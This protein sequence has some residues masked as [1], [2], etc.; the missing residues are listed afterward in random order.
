[1]R[2]K[3]GFSSWS[4]AGVVHGC[5]HHEFYF[6]LV[7][8]PLSA[9][10]L[11]VDVVAFLPVYFKSVLDWDAV[12]DV[13]EVFLFDDADG[14]FLLAVD[15]GD[16]LFDASATRFAWTWGWLHGVLFLDLLYLYNVK[17]YYT[18]LLTNRPKTVIPMHSR[19][20]IDGSRKDNMPT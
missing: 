17:S 5:F 16:D 19:H 2:I 1:M 11:V 6:L 8:L 9:G 13:E 20:L 18:L 14:E 7:E 12:E 10:D 15:L 4:I 3:K